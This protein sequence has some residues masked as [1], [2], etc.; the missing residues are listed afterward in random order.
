MAKTEVNCLCTI[1][2]LEKLSHTTDSPWAALSF[3]QL[4]KTGD[5]CFLIDFREVKK[6]IQR[7]PFPLPRIN[8]SLQKIEKFKS[9]TAIDLSQGYYSIP[10]SKKSQTICITISPLGKYAY[11]GLPMGIT[12]A[13]NIF[14]SIMMDLLGNLDYVLV[15][16]DDIL[17]LQR[18]GESEEDH[19]T[20]MEVVLKRLNN[21]GF[22]TNL[23]KSFFM[24]KKGR[25]PRICINN[26]CTKTSTIE[27]R[28]NA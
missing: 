28:S 13:P 27:D 8:K 24:Q 7:K 3:C 10:L 22:R 20:K 16:I 19:L 14:Q 6:C 18:H 23:C 2:I 25:I 9:A 15:Y 11:K 17:L 21:I 12:C 5:P 4:K 1:D 26:K